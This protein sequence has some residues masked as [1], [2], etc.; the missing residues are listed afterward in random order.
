M[1]GLTK[2]GDRASDNLARFLGVLD[3]GSTD[4]H[5]LKGLDP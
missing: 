1:V 5:S 4:L 3:A 2:L